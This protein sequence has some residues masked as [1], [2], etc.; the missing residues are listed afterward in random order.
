VRNCNPEDVAIAKKQAMRLYKLVD[1][2]INQG[3]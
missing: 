2:M 1:A 3:F